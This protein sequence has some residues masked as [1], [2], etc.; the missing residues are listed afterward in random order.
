MLGAPHGTLRLIAL[1][2]YLAGLRLLECLTLRMKDVDFARGEIRVRCGKGGKGRVTMLPA[3][4]KPALDRKAPASAT[5]LAWQCKAPFAGR[6]SR[7]GRRITRCGTLLRPTYWKT[8]TKYGRE[9]DHDPC[10][11][12]EPWGVGRSESG[13]PVG[14]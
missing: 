3:I 14:R 13:G 7:S 1:L 8:D 4:A 11:R 10:P 6:G 5:D 2:L 9:Y 12:T